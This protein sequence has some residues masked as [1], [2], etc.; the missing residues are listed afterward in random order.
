[1][2][3]RRVLAVVAALMLGM[4]LSGLDQTVVA[5]A[6]RTIGDDLGGVDQLAWLT[7]AFLITSTVTT[8]IY[9][10]LSDLFGRKSLYM[11]AI[12]LFLAGSALSGLA[13]SIPM[14]ALFRAIQG[15]GAGGLMTLAF[16]ITADVIAPKDRAKYQGYFAATMA[17]SSVLGPMVGGLFADAGTIAGVTGWRWA[18]WVN[19]PIGIAALIVV[20]RA[21]PGN[22]R[23]APG[24]ID[25]L[26][27]ALLTVALVPLLLVG[28]EGMEWGW[29]SA[30]SIWCYIIGGAG[31]IAFIAWQFRM[32]D[33]ALL[34]LG[35]MRQRAFSLPVLVTF[36]I[37]AAQFGGIV[38]LPLYL[39]IVL[40]A[41]PTLSG[42]LLIPMVLGM[43]ITSIIVGRLVSRTGRAK[44]FPILGMAVLTASYLGLTTVGT[45]TPL[46]VVDILMLGIGMGLGASANTIILLLQ[47]AVDFT[48]FGVASAAGTFFRNIGATTGTAVLLTVLFNRAQHAITAAYDTARNTP[49]FTAAAAEQP[50]QLATLHD[51]LARG[52]TDTSFLTHLDPALADPY[53]TGFTDAMHTVMLIAASLAATGLLLALALKNTPLWNAPAQKPEK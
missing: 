49:A 32:K 26:G 14:L 23:G 8:L 17:L 42:L 53:L 45:D 9:G 46:W 11:V 36:V 2:G 24:R 29:T 1:L 20:A 43:S 44:L 21:L 4:L 5:T 48:R 52:L 15:L 12:G 28:Q 6:S 30:A 19:V 27:I 10:K 40:G 16:A 3:H 47:S 34:P 18:F 41:S 22:R 39:Q 7:T 37:G 33:A 35:L 50:E 25:S 51:G 31:V 13:T 38:V